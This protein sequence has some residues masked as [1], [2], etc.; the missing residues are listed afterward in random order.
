[1]LFMAR[2]VHKNRI[3]EFNKCNLKQMKQKYASVIVQ[4]NLPEILGSNA[5]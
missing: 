5:N 4:E 3:I 2:F 1:M